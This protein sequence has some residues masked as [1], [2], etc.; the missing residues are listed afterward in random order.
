[1]SRADPFLLYYTGSLYKDRAKLRAL[2]QG[3]LDAAKE[4]GG[5]V[6]NAVSMG[7]CFGGAAVLEQARTGDTQNRVPLLSVPNLILDRC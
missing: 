1:M 4:Q 3:D 7:Y 5:D 2:L 6:T